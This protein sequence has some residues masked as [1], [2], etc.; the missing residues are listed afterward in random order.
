MLKRWCRGPGAAPVRSTIKALALFAT[1]SGLGGNITAE[2]A[3][4]EARDV[5]FGRVGAIEVATSVAVDN[6]NCERSPTAMGRSMACGSAR[7]NSMPTYCIQYYSRALWAEINWFYVQQVINKKTTTL[8]IHKFN[9]YKRAINH[10]SPVQLTRTWLVGEF[11]L[12][13]PWSERSAVGTRKL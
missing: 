5:L 8:H 1:R 4:Y 10:E 12:R 11:G 7:P 6:N 3:E 9:Q 2:V 13:V